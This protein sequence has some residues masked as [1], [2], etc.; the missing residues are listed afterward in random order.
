MLVSI[1]SMNI[2][3]ISIAFVKFKVENEKV[4]KF[5]K[6]TKHDQDNIKCE[7]LWQWQSLPDFD[8]ETGMY[9][10]DSSLTF[11][12]SKPNISTAQE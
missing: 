9:Y 2:F 4:I 12:H 5:Y 8:Q 7:E 11:K 3:F 6:Q 1:E 10:V